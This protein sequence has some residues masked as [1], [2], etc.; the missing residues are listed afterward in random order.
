[1]NINWLELIVGLVLGIFYSDIRDRILFCS[2]KQQFRKNIYDLFNF[3]LERC[4]QMDRQLTPQNGKIEIPNYLFDTDSIKA[5]IFNGREYF[6]NQGEFDSI[7]WQ[8]Y[9]LDHLN[10]KLAIIGDGIGTGQYIPEF[11]THLSREKK[12]IEALLG[13]WK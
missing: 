10:N 5:L 4:V 6:S 9:Q 11:R 8:R 2:K 7:N 3:N 13:G 12:A 1:M